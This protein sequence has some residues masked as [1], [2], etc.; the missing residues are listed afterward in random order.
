MET[1]KAVLSGIKYFELIVDVDQNTHTYL[2]MKTD[3]ENIYWL[4]QSI[5]AEIVDF[6]SVNCYEPK[7]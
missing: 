3:F 7:V 5:K 1:K 6:K 4:T 2:P